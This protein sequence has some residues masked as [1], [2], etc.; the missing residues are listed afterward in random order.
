MYKR[1]VV[2]V[3]ALV[4]VRLVVWEGGLVVAVGVQVVVSVVVVLVLVMLVQ[5]L[6]LV[7]GGGVGVAAADGGFRCVCF[8]AVAVCFWSSC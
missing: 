1:Q 8:L 7:A 5:V 2:L 3:L 6:V 4:L